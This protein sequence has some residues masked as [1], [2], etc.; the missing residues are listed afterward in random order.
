MQPKAA[1]TRNMY[2]TSS[3]SGDNAIESGL[4]DQ[5]LYTIW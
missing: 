1:I 2:E 4:L 5:V 3:K